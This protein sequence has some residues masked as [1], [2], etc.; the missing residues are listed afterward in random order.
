MTDRPN[1]LVF[2]PDQQRPD[3]LGCYGGAPATPTIDELASNGRRFTSAFATSPLCSPSRASMFTGLYPH[4]HGVYGNDVPLPENNTTFVELLADVGYRTELIGKWHLGVP[5]DRHTG[6]LWRDAPP[7]FDSM[8]TALEHDVPPGEEPD[9]LRYLKREGVVDTDADETAWRDVPDSSVPVGRSAIPAE[10]HFTT[11]LVDRAIEFLD[12][13]DDESPFYLQLS[14]FYPH[15]PIAPPA[16]YDRMYDPDAIELPESRTLES[17]EDKPSLETATVARS[18]YEEFSE[19]DLRAAWAL[20]YGLC[21]HIDTQLGR[22]LEALCDRNLFEDTVVVY[23][24]D[25]GEMLGNH[26]LL[27]KG[28]FMYDDVLR[29]PLLV[30]HPSIESGETDSLVSLADLPPTL[31]EL[32]GCSFPAETP[33]QSFAPILFGERSDHRSTVYAEYLTDESTFGA[34]PDHPIFMVRGK[35]YKYAVTDGQGEVLY[36]LDDR[37]AEIHNRATDPDYRAVKRSVRTRLDRI[38]PSAV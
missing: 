2:N 11:W 10:H 29:V 26:G 17:F 33:G 18:D 21:T 12:S 24:S 38:R 5:V 13:H 20:T 8:A 16:P 25:H 3:G 19:D 9:Y 15:F 22:L 27:W 31:A 1:I 4:E 34:N 36:D 37:P 7:G 14:G 30:S 32:A 6:T 28:P 35:R 23:V